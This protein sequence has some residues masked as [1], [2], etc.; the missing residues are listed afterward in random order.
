MTTQTKHMTSNGSVAWLK[1]L[2][3][4]ENQMKITLIWTEWVEV[5]V[6][7]VAKIN[8]PTMIFSVQVMC[9]KKISFDQE[10]GQWKLLLATK[11]TIII[12]LVKVSMRETNVSDMII[13]L[14][15]EAI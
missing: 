13:S 5:K 15:V 10:R 7:L 14:F 2:K 3:S 12:I 8:T 9:F 4:D 11:S 1:N 6:L